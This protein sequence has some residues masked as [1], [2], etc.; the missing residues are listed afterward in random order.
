MT[1]KNTIS[2]WCDKFKHTVCK[3]IRLLEVLIFRSRLFHCKMADRRTIFL[4]SFEI[5]FEERSILHSSS[6]VFKASFEV[7]LIV[8]IN[9]SKHYIVPVAITDKKLHYKLGCK[10]V[11]LSLCLW[12]AVQ[13]LVERYKAYLKDFGIKVVKSVI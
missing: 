9:A 11:A 2:R 7:A 12:S 3:N 5:F 6:I 13:I 10:Y 4:N 8:P 1:V